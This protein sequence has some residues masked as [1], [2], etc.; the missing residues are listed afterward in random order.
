MKWA[1][2]ADVPPIAAAWVSP[3][4]K[5]QQQRWQDA[6]AK[7]ED[8]GTDQTIVRLWSEEHYRGF[9]I[10]TGQIE[11][12]YTLRPGVTEMLITEGLENA[13]ASH[14]VEQALDDDT[15]KGLLADQRDAIEMVFLSVKDERPL[16]TSTIKEW[17]A[18]LTRHQAGAPARDPQGRLIA[19]PFVK[20]DYKRRPNNPRTPDGAVHE[21]CPPEQTASEMDRLLAM[22]RDH[23]YTGELP[24]PVEAAWLHHRFVQIH[25]FEDGNGRTARLLMSYVFA[26]HA[27]PS[28]VFAAAEKQAYF[29]VLQAADRGDLQP[30]VELLD[31]KATRALRN[32]TQTIEEA[33]SAHPEYRHTNGDVTRRTGDNLWKRLS[34]AYHP[35]AEELAASAENKGSV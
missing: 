31:E 18:L 3:A 27:E 35:T 24:A 33:L 32:G 10:E 11:Q 21:Y 6:R 16:S 15:L 23:E 26:K 30:F 29:R 14:T 8:R 7:L 25:P 20:G 1:P 12:L 9:A 17:H 2:I 34:R 13:R 4:Y 22:H 19:V 28:P 5:T